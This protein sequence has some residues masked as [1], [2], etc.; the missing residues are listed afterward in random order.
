MRKVDKQKSMKRFGAG[1]PPRVEQTAPAECK[2]SAIRPASMQPSGFSERDGSVA[3]EHK[4]L[5][6]AILRADG[7]NE[8]IG[9]KTLSGTV[10]SNRALSESEAGQCRDKETS[11]EKMHA[12]LNAADENGVNLLYQIYRISA[13]GMDM[14]KFI[15]QT[16]ALL[17]HELHI[18]ALLSYL[19]DDVTKQVRRYH[20]IG[21]DITQKNEAYIFPD[22]LMQQAMKR[23]RGSDG[24]NKKTNLYLDREQI[25]ELFGDY[26]DIGTFES[27]IL[28][29]IFSDETF[30]GSMIVFLRKGELF[31]PRSEKIM[32]TVC[33]QLSTLI[34]NIRLY[35]TLTRELEEH[36]QVEEELK[37]ANDELVNSAYTDQLTGLWNRRGLIK[38]VYE[39]IELMRIQKNS[40]SFLLLD[41][42]HFKRVNDKY[43]HQVGDMVLIDFADLL[44]ANS[45]TTDSITRWGGE[46]FLILT[47]TN[48]GNTAYVYAERLR[49]LVS[50]HEF[51]VIGEMTVSIGIAELREGEDFDSWIKRVDDALYAAKDRDRNNVVV[52]HEGE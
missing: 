44:R 16:C 22:E 13:H 32:I 2:Q 51:P 45:R 40:L 33:A 23:R 39:Q 20:C 48:V 50:L 7:K 31:A 38:H 46:E 27:S 26:P 37:K 42:D 21:M 43:G 28:F 47:T 6:Q 12:V 35:N 34:Q 8:D 41:I 49:K 15:R 1:H 14:D 11:S 9:R 29:P 4:Y 17:S 10:L 30:L 19:F 25:L 52:N 3:V 24:E 18:D 5:S 36:K